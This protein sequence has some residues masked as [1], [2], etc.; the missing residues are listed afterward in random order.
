M[1]PQLP[2]IPTDPLVG[3]VLAAVAV[4]VMSACLAYRVTRSFGSV[5]AGCTGTAG[6]ERTP[7]VPDDEMTVECR[8]CGAEN[9]LGY[10]YCRECVA[11]LP[12]AV[13][14]ERS[15]TD[16]PGRLLE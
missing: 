9:E 12:G 14:F 13:G 3:F 7:G 15:A 4:N 8:E 6:R 11:E 1:V 2:G 10:R 16:S 5:V